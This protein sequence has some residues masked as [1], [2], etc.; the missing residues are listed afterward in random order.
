MDYMGLPITQALPMLVDCLTALICALVL[1][2]IVSG[3]LIT[4]DRVA[5]ALCIG[6]D[7]VVSAR[8][9]MFALGCIQAMQCHKNTCPTGITMHDER[10][11]KRL[12][13]QRKIGT[14]CPFC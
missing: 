1:K 13:A 14:R 9:F 11:C 5:L 12:S 8:G 7:M 10:F 6:A 4:P 3:K 2:V